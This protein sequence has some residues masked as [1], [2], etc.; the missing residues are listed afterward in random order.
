MEGRSQRQRG[1]VNYSEGRGN[2]AGSGTPLWL[3]RTS[4]LAEKSAGE[5]AAPAK[6]NTQPAPS[7]KARKE[8]GVA[9]RGRNAG[10]SVV[11]IGAKRSEQGLAASPPVTNCSASWAAVAS[12]LPCQRPQSHSACKCVPCS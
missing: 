10:V 3:K 1:A 5:N 9:Q 7:G 12:A 6:E 2:T 11:P 8:A 4:S